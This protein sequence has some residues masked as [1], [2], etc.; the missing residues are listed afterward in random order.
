MNKKTNNYLI[1]LASFSILSFLTLGGILHTNQPLTDFLLTVLVV[2]L[3]IK[4]VED[5]ETK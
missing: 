4:H 2:H 1:M 5:L 3:V